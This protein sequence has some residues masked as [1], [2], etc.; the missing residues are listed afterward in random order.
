MKLS[1]L[2]GS[3]FLASACMISTC[4]RII[5]M[6]ALYI[7]LW[8][9]A[10]KS[11]MLF[12]LSRAN[13]FLESRAASSLILFHSYF[14]SISASKISSVEEYGLEFRV[15]FFNVDVN[16]FSC[17][18]SSCVLFSPTNCFEEETY[19]TPACGL[20]FLSFSKSSCTLFFCTK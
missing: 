7:L 6:K 12:A 11:F 4:L 1:K 2:Y 20:A 8:N 18:I 15:F 10:L 5:L 17:F 3:S 14:L 13:N 19:G 9:F 16:F